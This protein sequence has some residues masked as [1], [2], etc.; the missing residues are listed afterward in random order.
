MRGKKG[1]LQMIGNKK[2][3]ESRLLNSSDEDF[4]GS[5]EQ[6]FSPYSM[7]ERIELGLLAKMFLG[8]IGQ[9]IFYCILVIYLY[10][11]LAIYAVIVSNSLTDFIGPLGSLQTNHTYYIW[12][13]V[14]ALIMT[15]FTFFNFQKTKYLQFTTLGTRNTALL[16]MIVFSIVILAR[17]GDPSTM[18]QGAHSSIPWFDIGG[19]PKM[20]GVGIYAFMC[21]HS[22]PS[23]VTPVRNK[24]NLTM[25]LAGVFISIGIVYVVLCSTAV[26]AFGTEHINSLYN[27]NFNKD[28][29]SFLPSKLPSIIGGFL[30]L[31]PV[32]T[33]TSNFPLIAITLRNNLTILFPSMKGSFIKQCQLSLIAVIPPLIIAFICG[34]FRDK[35]SQILIAIT[36][37]YPGLAI[38]FVI[39][40][41]LVYTSRRR[42]KEVFP[43]ESN[44]HSSPFS[45]VVF[46]CAILVACAVALGFIIYNQVFMFKD[47][48]EGRVTAGGHK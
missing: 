17:G 42:M 27:T 25:L 36:G 19:T 5:D 34:L 33:L 32:F 7:K 45:H 31:F 10:G 23:L 20:F 2:T 40:A 11:D 12:L 41:A 24:K 37:S 28:S 6:S 47:M 13:S 48:I 1:P 8:N 43:G 3:E 4:D 35:A 16:M 44:I 21:H 9:K 46:I 30:A 38:M 14:F 39:P 18:Q 26:L 22:L 15:P 29:L